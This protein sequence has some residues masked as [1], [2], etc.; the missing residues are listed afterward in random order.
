MTSLS[1]MA[2]TGDYNL[3]QIELPE[4]LVEIK[5]GFKAYV[6]YLKQTDNYGEVSIGLLNRNVGAFSY[7]SISSITLPA[8]LQRIGAYA[9]YGCDK[10]NRIY[11]NALTPPELADEIDAQVT[12]YVPKGCSELYKSDAMW[13]TALEIVEM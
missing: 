6:T 1:S 8:S 5:D 12:V 11:C 7:T 10:L 3:S 2:F 4:S 13:S 9:F